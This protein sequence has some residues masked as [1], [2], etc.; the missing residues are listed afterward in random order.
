[1]V[2]ERMDNMT[3]EERRAAEMRSI[4]KMAGLEAPKEEKP[5]KKTAKKAETQ[6]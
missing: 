1:M 4:M 5:A 3:E 6:E 2:K